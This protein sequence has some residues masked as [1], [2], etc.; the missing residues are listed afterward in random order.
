MKVQEYDQ[1]RYRTATDR[2]LA[3]AIAY[4]SRPIGHTTTVCNSVGGENM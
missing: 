2:E 3:V 1:H 4:T